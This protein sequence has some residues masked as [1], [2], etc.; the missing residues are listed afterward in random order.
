VA[1]T[2]QKTIDMTEGPIF[3]KLLAFAIPLML[4]GI[5]LDTKQLVRS[6][7]TRTFGAARFLRGEGADP[8]ETNELFKNDV[9]DMRKQAQFLTNVV[10]YRERVAIAVCMGN[11]DSSYRVIAAKAADSLL[12]GRGVSASFALV[13]IGSKVHVSARSDGTVNVAKIL[14]EFHGGGHFDAAGAQMDPSE[15][16]IEKLKHAIDKHLDNEE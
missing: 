1:Q 13:T 6:T 5:L 7:G 9:T 15:E 2:K 12:S 10:L 11:T 3:G 16:N 4:S 8:S 14:E